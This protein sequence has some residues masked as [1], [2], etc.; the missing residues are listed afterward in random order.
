[1]RYHIPDDISPFQ[2]EID[3]VK[4]AGFNLIGV[5]QFMFYT[6]FIFETQDEADE[7]HATLENIDKPV[8]S[9]WW[10]GKDSMP[11]AIRMYKESSPENDR[12]FEVKIFWL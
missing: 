2:Y 1:M 9:G 7:A 3:I 8:V 10:Y 11:E 12:N 6:A 5:T 4:N